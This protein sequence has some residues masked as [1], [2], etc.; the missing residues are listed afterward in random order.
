MSS[1]QQVDAT[2]WSV[3]V[4]LIHHQWISVLWFQLEKYLCDKNFLLFDQ[5][6]SI[7]NVISRYAHKCCEHGLHDCEMTLCF[8]G[9][10]FGSK[11]G[12]LHHQFIPFVILYII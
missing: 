6:I 12:K 1:G 4:N 2:H 3:A 9:C 11:I 7:P 10:L 5:L 8:S